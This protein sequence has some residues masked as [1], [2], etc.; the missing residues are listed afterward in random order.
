MCPALTISKDLARVMS[1][2]K[3]VYRSWAIPC[4]ELTS[5][6]QQPFVGLFVI[7]VVGVECVGC[8]VFD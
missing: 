7:R 4:T 2:L 3:A 5:F 6:F 1:R 8:S